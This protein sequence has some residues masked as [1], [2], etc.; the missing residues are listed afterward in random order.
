MRKAAVT[1]DQCGRMEDA[2]MGDA[3]FGI[4]PGGWIPVVF[5]PA[6][7]E[8]PVMPLARKQNA[9]LC[10]WLCV[11]AYAAERTPEEARR[12]PVQAAPLDL[13]AT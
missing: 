3:A 2:P 1:C 7:G 12:G 9:D 13:G 6:P 10:S 5:D 11:S 4:L 8:P